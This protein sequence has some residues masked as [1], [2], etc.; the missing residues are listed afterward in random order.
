ME[1]KSRLSSTPRPTNH[2]RR[3]TDRDQIWIDLLHDHGGLSTPILTSFTTQFYKP[4]SSKPDVFRADQKN[5]DEAV[6]RLGRLFDAGLLKKPASQFE[7]AAADRHHLIYDLSDEGRKL[8][9]NSKCSPRIN[10]AIIKHDAMPPAITAS[11]RY[12][13]KDTGIK[14]IPQHKILE[15][16]A[17]SL[18][19]EDILGRTL[20]PDAIFGL[21]FP[22]GKTRYY[23]VEADRGTEPEESDNPNRKDIRRN[24]LQY[25][26][27][28]GEGIYKNHFGIDGGM[29][30]LNITN[31]PHRL[32]NMVDVAA[33][34]SKSGKSTFSFYQYTPAFGVEYFRPPNKIISHYTDELWQRA[35]HDPFNLLTPPA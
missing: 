8:S 32:P 4:R 22:N 2:K 34:A 16:K 18:V 25:R 12:M 9:E 5:H 29:V 35:G 11:I 27:L 23:C 24:Y 3:I 28:I 13:L 17:K 19:I 10:T 14:Y 6:K 20:T 30:V 7:V 31:K 26:E 33:K 1:R 15:L 21:E